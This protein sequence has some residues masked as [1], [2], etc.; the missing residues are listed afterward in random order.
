MRVRCPNKDCPFDV[1]DDLVG[2][3]VRCPH[4]FH[5]FFVER[6]EDA[7]ATHVQAAASNAPADE[8]RTDPVRI[9]NQI[10]DGLP[11]LA[12]MMALRR[13]QANLDDIP[14][15]LEMT[16]EDWQAL[17]AFE[18]VLHAEWSL[19]T[20]LI[21]GLIAIAVNLL[22]AGLS[23]VQERSARDPHAGFLALALL[24]PPIIMLIPGLLHVFTG[25]QRLG[26]L[27]VD[28]LVQWLP[29]TTFC[30][31]CLFFTYVVAHLMLIYNRD[32][33]SLVFVA[34]VGIGVNLIAGIDG[35]KAWLQVARGLRE[36]AP[37]EIL[38]RLTEALK[39]VA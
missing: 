29:I 9:E 25:G 23:F 6:E 18:Q 34:V 27:R 17:S 38:R 26:R 21:Y 28:R 19:R 30:N 11:P 36:V 2:A 10:Y 16:D 1:P 5:L 13:Q 22:M 3:R 20:S 14:A 7:G 12:V 32:S 8:K 35:S 15:E 39:F 4:C 24:A 31:A 33:E 37:P